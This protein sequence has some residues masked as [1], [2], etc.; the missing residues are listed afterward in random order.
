MDHH[1]VALS[2]KHQDS[3]QVAD[4]PSNC[5]RGLDIQH[6]TGRVGVNSKG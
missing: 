1:G 4:A 6:L 3:L 5:F 2:F